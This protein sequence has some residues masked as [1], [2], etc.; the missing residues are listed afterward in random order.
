MIYYETFNGT[1]AA[2]NP[3]HITTV[4][5]IEMGL[6]VEMV[7]GQTVLLR[8]WTMDSLY[9]ILSQRLSSSQQAME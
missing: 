6:R 9:E 5:E 8:E 1:P 7:N 4:V 2:I 3:D